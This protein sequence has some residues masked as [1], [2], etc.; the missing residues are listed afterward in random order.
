MKAFP[1]LLGL[2]AAFAA[3]VAEGQV[4]HTSFRNALVRY[5]TDS[6]E[7]TFT[8]AKAPEG[9]F[10]RARLSLPEGCGPFK[11]WKVKTVGSCET[12]RVTFAK[13]RLAKDVSVEFACGYD[14]ISVAG[15]DGLRL[16]GEIFAGAPDA[17]SVFAVAADRPP[18]GLA[19][20][21]GGAVP[22]GADA[23]FDRRTDV[24]YR[25]RGGTL[26]WN[27]AS[28]RFVFSAE[29]RLSLAVEPNLLAS[30]YRI[31]YRPINPN[32]IFRTPPVGW[33]TWY[34][35]KFGASDEVVMRNARGF[36]E[37]FRGYT[38]E[39]PVLWVDWEWFHDRFEGRGEDNQDMITPR[40]SVYPR[41]MKPVADD[42]SV[43]GFTPALWV[44]IINDVRTNALWQAHNEWILGESKT[45]CGY[46]WGD[47]S[48]PGFCEEYVPTLFGMYRDWGYKAFKWDCLPAAIGKFGE[49]HDKL[50]NPKLLPEEVYRRMV[51]AGRKAVGPDCYLESCS[52]ENDRPILGAID[53]FDAGRIGGDIFAWH[54][55]LRSGVNQLLNYYPLHGTV[56]WADADNLVLRA[57]FS[58]LAQARTRA[59]VYALAGVPITLGD[60]IAA[61]DAPRIDILRRV[62][63]VVPMH[64]ASMVRNRCPGG[65]MESTADFARD[66]GSWRLKAWS[67]FTT[68]ETLSASF[69]APGCAVWDFWND[70]LVTADC[71]SPQRLSVEPGDTALWRVTPLEKVG[72]TLLSVSR[73]VTQ[74]GYEIESL[75]IGANGAKGAVK[76]P[77][78]ETVKVTFLLPEGAKVMAASHPCDLDGRVLRLKVD[79][80][81]KATV[82]F[83]Y[84]ISQGRNSIK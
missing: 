40:T 56:F 34:A 53:F 69:A 25:V 30:R 2:V 3:T 72:P 14:G 55:F 51:A 4:F 57:E 84:N 23:V 79:S 13:G 52:G 19:S 63:P 20:A 26:R 80:P 28:R 74:G 39:K 46:L 68:N 37:N 54:E 66:F 70:R 41:G 7:V 64:P 43:L 48:A 35:V 22:E 50:K 29:G 59:T 67:N 42:L 8:D 75:I 49:L 78:G 10:A 18:S 9:V 71:R 62:M 5:D 45:W 61:L 15:S 17:E 60:E 12:G 76:C 32:C 36:M 33:M 58:S 81:E 82:S 1:L 24:L 16:D 77:G 21:S 31:A 38:D 44:S 11:G 6:G 47:P 73:H 27:R 65:L 83:W